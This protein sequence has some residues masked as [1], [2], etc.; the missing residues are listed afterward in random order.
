MKGQTIE[1][2]FGIAAIDKGFI[3]AEQLIEA[4]R[5]QIIGDIEQKDHK[6][7]GTILLEMGLVTREQIDEVVKELANKRMSKL[8]PP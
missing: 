5:I 7:I 6:L 4:L 3:T 1:I 2:R 8:S